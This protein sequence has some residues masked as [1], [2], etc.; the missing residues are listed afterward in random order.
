MEGCERQV[1]CAEG[2]ASRARTG[3]GTPAKGWWAAICAMIALVFGLLTVGFFAT[4]DVDQ[5]KQPSDEELTIDF[6]SH[7][8]IFDEL[9]QIL[10]M[11][12][13]TLAA[14]GATVVDLATMARLDTNAIRIGMY[15]GLLRQISVADLRYFTESGKLILVPDG[16]KNPERPPKSYLYLP[17]GRPQSLVPY[18]GS[19]WRAPGMYILIGDRP[20]KGAWFIHHDMTIEVAV[21]PY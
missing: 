5:N 20:L 13:P 21:P 11:D 9:V 19:D 18:Y 3:A 15:R 12:R 14:K 17:H 6:F 8:A 1:D 10:A 7:E 2:T 4:Y 16:Q